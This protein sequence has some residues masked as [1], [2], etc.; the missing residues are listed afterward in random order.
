MIWPI[1]TITRI[2][3]LAF[4][5][6]SPDQRNSEKSDFL[7]CLAP[8]APHHTAQTPEKKKSSSFLDQLAINPNYLAASRNVM[9][10]TM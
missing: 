3:L 10:K 4:E 8:K 6:A 5:A 1:V 2:I 7:Q 9:L